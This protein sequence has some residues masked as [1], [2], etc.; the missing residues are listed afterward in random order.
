MVFVLHLTGLVHCF[1]GVDQGVGWEAPSIGREPLCAGRPMQ[2][3][4]VFDIW[5][6]H[7]DS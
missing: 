6:Y 3:T 4:I 7:R 1:I 5:S 2:N